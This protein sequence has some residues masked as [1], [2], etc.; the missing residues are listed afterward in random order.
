M[1]GRKK[2]EETAAEAAEAVA[3]Q[4]AA[5]TGDVAGRHV[6]SL[7]GYAALEGTRKERF[8]KI[9]EK[10]SE[11]V[12]E[13]LIKTL[14]QGGADISYVEWHV[15]TD[16]LDRVCPDW[17][18]EITGIKDIAGKIATTV[19]ITIEGVRRENIGIEDL[20]VDSYGD[21]A[22]NSFSTAFKR[23]AA[24]F[25]VGRHLYKKDR[26]EGLQT[27]ATGTPR[28]TST[29]A[30]AKPAPRTDGKLVAT[31]TGI[32]EATSKA[33]KPYAYL[34]VVVP[35]EKWPLKQLFN[36]DFEEYDLGLL[37]GLKGA[38][39]YPTKALVTLDTS[40]KWTN[41]ATY[42]PYEEPGAPAESAGDPTGSPVTEDDIPF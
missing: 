20:S 19:A 32:K 39:K 3:V 16:I 27:P 8:Q 31:L 21:F 26:P 18:L 38:P 33:G 4:E 13:E 41:I 40:G 36:R 12:P 28:A 29:A 15:V 35:G 7:I 37:L 1:A 5:E 14:K 30:A 42:E 23:S 6:D 25:G 10:L 24:L 11:E 22:V 34:E 2:T 9:L 17:E